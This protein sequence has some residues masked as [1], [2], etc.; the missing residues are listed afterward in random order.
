[1]GR[2]LL[3]G[4][5]KVVRAV[6]VLSGRWEAILSGLLISIL[7]IFLGKFFNIISPSVVVSVGFFVYGQAGLKLVDPN[8]LYF[9]HLLA[10]V[11]A[12]MGVIVFYIS[13]GGRA[14]VM[15]AYSYAGG[16]LAGYVG[17]WISGLFYGLIY[18]LPV[19]MVG[20]I[21]S[22][23]TK[24]LCLYIILFALDVAGVVVLL[25]LATV[26]VPGIEGLV[27]ALLVLIRFFATPVNGAYSSILSLASSGGVLVSYNSVTHLITSFIITIVIPILLAWRW[28]R[29]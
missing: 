17:V 12:I 23:T 11:S 6:G 13:I 9:A 24:T 19:A 14:S 25:S 2:S 5:V 3:L 20:Y 8:S 15:F 4:A 29:P 21:T 28:G 10:I 27:G 26:R 7:F 1:L 16:P 18:S 22:L